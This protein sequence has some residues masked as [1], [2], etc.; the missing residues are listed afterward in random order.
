MKTGTILIIDDSQSVLNSLELLLKHHFAKII[1]LKSPNLIPNTLSNEDIDVVLLDMNFT[2]GINTGNEGIYWLRRILK[3]DP[4]IV[5]VMITAYGDVELAVK[6]IKEGAT[7]FI[8]KPWDN[9]KLLTTIQASLKL[10]NSRKEVS[11]L[12]L[13]QKQFSED[14]NKNFTSIIGESEEIKNLMKTIGKVAATDANVLIMGENGTGKEL[15]AREIHRQSKRVDNDFVSV[16]L[17]ALSESLFESEMFGHIKGAYTDAKEDRIGRFEA[18]N[19]GSL[20]LDEIGN[21]NF[22]LQSKLLTAIEQ[23]KVSPLG[24]NKEIPVDI[25]LITAT[26]KDLSAQVKEGL[27]REDLYY[28]LNTIQIVVPPLRDRGEDIVLLSEYYLKI[29]SAKYEK[30]GLRFKSEALDKLLQY[31]WPGNIRELRHTIEKSVILCE[32]NFISAGD[33]NFSIKQESDE[34]LKGGISLEDAERLLIT[35]SLN[36]YNWNISEAAKEL[37]IG[38]QTLYRKIEKYG[39]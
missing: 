19:G 29:Y 32:N 18:A 17:G 12:K 8:L 7:D 36:R 20:F 38:R 24:S 25:R 3:E 16:D 27:F 5:V 26:N 33:F 14:L 21:L 39:I 10:H 1:T 13:K 37:G 2:S 4:S 23:R 28:R 22:S 15:I 30:P 9:H 35:N 11:K 31:N 34:S 6:A